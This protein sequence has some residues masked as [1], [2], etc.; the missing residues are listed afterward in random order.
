ME[1]TFG[2]QTPNFTAASSETLRWMLA[3]FSGA[4]TV[5]TSITMPNLVDWDCSPTEGDV[6]CSLFFVRHTFE[7]YSLC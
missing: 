3:H 7:Q 6:W 4:K 5:W 2:M 1:M